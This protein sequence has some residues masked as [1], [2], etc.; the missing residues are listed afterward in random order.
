MPEVGE[1]VWA[2]GTSTSLP[3]FTGSGSP[4]VPKNSEKS[5]A[6]RPE[7]ASK[8]RGT[9]ARTARAAGATPGTIIDADGAGAEVR[10]ARVEREEAP[11][12]FEAASA[13]S[14]EAC[15]EMEASVAEFGEALALRAKAPRTGGDHRCSPESI[16]DSAE[17]SADLES[18][19]AVDEE[20]SSRPGNAS[21]LRQE[22]PG[23]AR[24]S[25]RLLR[26][27]S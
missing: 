7:D 27:Q 10:D 3:T 24:R 20:A 23:D 19:S 6:K 5:V 17:T 2:F 16:P 26:K 4:N 15:P 21:A 18:A 25:S 14:T 8:R 22:A 9:T 12:N 11:A 13:A 1:A